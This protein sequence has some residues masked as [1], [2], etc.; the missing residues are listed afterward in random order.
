MDKQGTGNREQGSE[1]QVSGIRDQESER[2][3]GHT[4]TGA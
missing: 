1:E 3:D 2:D 4:S